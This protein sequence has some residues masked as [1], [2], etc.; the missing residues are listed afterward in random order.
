MIVLT[1]RTYRKID[2][3]INYPS[4]TGGLGVRATRQPGGSVTVNIPPTGDGAGLP[5]GGPPGLP[6]DPSYLPPEPPYD[7]YEPITPS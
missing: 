4:V 6:Y 5:V 7:P 1:Q 2:R 3:A